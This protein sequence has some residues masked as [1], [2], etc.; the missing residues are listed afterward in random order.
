MRQAT[1]ALITS[2]LLAALAVVAGAEPLIADEGKPAYECHRG[3]IVVDGLVDDDEWADAESTDAFVFPWPHQTG[4]KQSTVAKLLWDD[5]FL[6]VG[7]Q[8]EDG[9]ITALHVERDDPTYKDDCVEIFIAPR[10][11]KS[12]MYYGFEL[13]CRGVLYDYFFAFPD[14]LL[15]NWDA[16]GV[17]LTSAIAGTLNQSDDEDLGWQL[18]IAI[19]LKNFA[20][21]SGKQRPEP[22][23]VWRINMN[24]WD[25]TGSTRA[26]S[27]WTPSGLEAAHPHRP[28]GFGALK[29]M[30][31]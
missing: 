7:Y 6:Y 28:E 17:R 14:C 19:P 22:G 13:N 1:Q 15:S 16:H 9:D 21:L 5:R 23:D 11:D 18:E 2:V 31:E 27:E 30:G 3:T 24:R 8:C 4:P 25:G 10:P 26:L 12:R 20:A 29:F